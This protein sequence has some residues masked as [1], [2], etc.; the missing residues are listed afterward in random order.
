M[1]QNS[2]RKR[3]SNY[4]RTIAYMPYILSEIE[5]LKLAMDIFYKGVWGT[6][7]KNSDEEIKRYLE[8]TQ[9]AY[10]KW[11]SSEFAEKPYRKEINRLLKNMDKRELPKVLEYLKHI[12]ENN[13]EKKHEEKNDG[14]GTH[15]TKQNK[16]CQN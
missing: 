3:G 6:S 1:K 15:R 12:Q 5:T 14:A 9:D 4:K 10:F 2:R 11:F 7:R 16:G 13:K 8:Y